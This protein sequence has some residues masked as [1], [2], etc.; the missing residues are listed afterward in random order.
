MT[1]TYPN[2]TGKGFALLE[3]LVKDNSKAW[4]DA[5]RD[6]VKSHLLDPFAD[7][8]EAVSD[9]LC[10]TKMPLR[11]GRQTMF[12]MHRDIRFSK[13]K[14]PYKEAVAGLLTSSGTKS[15][16]QGLVYLHLGPSGGFVAGGFYKLTAKQLGPI[17]DRIVA[18]P[19]IFDRVL[20]TLADADLELDDE[21]SLKSMPRGFAEHANHKHADV[22]R[23][24]SLIA[25]NL[26]PK[27]AWLDGSVVDRTV[28]HAKACGPL[29]AFGRDAM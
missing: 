26:M 10:K 15:E 5:H 13:D 2:I 27:S 24:Q 16:M 12:R 17:R 14:R 8:L 29:I 6:D 22:L 7:V 23:C 9:A 25:Q 1:R 4:F 21:S 18:E 19:K 28:S 11:G 20:K 3:G